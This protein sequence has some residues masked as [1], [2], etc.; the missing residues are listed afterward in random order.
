M[1]KPEFTSLYGNAAEISI[2]EKKVCDQIKITKE[3][4]AILA[5]NRH[6]L[7]PDLFV[8]VFGLIE[9]FKNKHRL[10]MAVKHDWSRIFT[11][12]GVKS[13]HQKQNVVY[14]CDKCGLTTEVIARVPKRKYHGALSFTE[15]ETI[16]RS[17]PDTCEDCDDFVVRKVLDE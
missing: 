7:E 1:E 5:K 3:L 12:I 17:I 14:K 13:L 2:A 9:S 16:V 8:Q 6:I 11:K 10:I 4:A 15:F